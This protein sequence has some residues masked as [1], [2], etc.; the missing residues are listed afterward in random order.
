MDKLDKIISYLDN[1]LK[2]NEIPDYPGALNGLQLRGKT[3]IKK[4]GAAVDA[5][6]PVIYKAIDAKVDLLIVH[7]GIFW[8]GAQKIDGAL[9]KKIKASI[10]SGMA[11]YSSHIPLDV[12]SKFGNNTLMAKAIGLKGGKPFLEWKGLKIGLQFDYKIKRKQ[13]IKQIENSINGKVHLAPGGKETIKRIG[14]ITGGAGSEV[15]AAAKEGIDTFITGE[16][17]HHTFT[18]AEELG[19]NLIY[20]GHYLSETFGVKKIAAHIGEKFKIKNTFIDHPTGL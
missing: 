4:V 18:L 11:I 6:L 13:L 8:E 15:K 10:D 19:V 7:H 20:A 2:N 9:Y 5:A 16:G 17:A 12:H 3:N 14:I 1:T